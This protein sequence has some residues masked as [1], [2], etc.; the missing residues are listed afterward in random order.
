MISAEYRAYI[1][2]PYPL[3]SARLSERSLYSRSGCRRYPTECSDIGIAASGA[4]GVGWIGSPDRG[5]LLGRVTGVVSPA[6]YLIEQEV[7]LGLADGMSA[8]SHEQTVE[9][10]PAAFRNGA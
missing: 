10:R 8:P 1:C 5:R 7:E 6:Q 2:A 3:P 4:Q 9:G